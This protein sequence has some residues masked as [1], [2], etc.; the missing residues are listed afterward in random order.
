MTAHRPRRRYTSQYK[1]EILRKADACTKPG[2]V[3]ALLRK[4]HQEIKNGK[5][6]NEWQDR[7][8]SH[9]TAARL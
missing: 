2:E 7:H 6:E 4:D 8:D 3:A 9:T 5:Y 1:L